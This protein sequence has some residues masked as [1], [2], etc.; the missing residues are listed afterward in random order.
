MNYFM[1]FPFL[2]WGK[3]HMHIFK[4]NIICIY[5]KMAGTSLAWV[6]KK[7]CET[8]PCQLGITLEYQY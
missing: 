8:E 4:E 5:F 7:L 6:P 3:P 2:S 1:L